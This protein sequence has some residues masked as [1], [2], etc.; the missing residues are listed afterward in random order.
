MSTTKG[1]IESNQPASP[2]LLSYP[3]DMS[4]F[5]LPLS[6]NSNTVT[7][8]QQLELASYHPGTIAQYALARWQQYLD[9]K[10]QEHI[11][12][13]LRLA[14]WLLDTENRIG[15]QAGGW[16]TSLPHPDVPTQ[17]PWLSALAQGCALSVF[18]RAYQFTQ[19]PQFLEVAHRARRT[20]QQDI[21]DG[22]VQTP[23]GANGVFFEEVGQYPAA[24]MLN[25]YI[26][27]I[28]GLYDY[29]ACTGDAFIEALIVDSIT[30]MHSILQEFDTGFWTYSNLLN[31]HLSSPEQLA[32]QVTLLEALAIRSQCNH[33][34]ALAARWKRY[35]H[36]PTSRLRHKIAKDTRK[37]GN[38]L[39]KRV[40]TALLPER[41]IEPPLR[42]CV[43]LNSLFVTGG[44]L[45]V[46]RGIAQVTVGDWQMEFLTRYVGERQDD[47]VVH[48]FGNQLMAPWQFPT[49]WV[50][51][52]D[53]FTKFVSLMRQG[54]GYHLIMPQDGVFSAAF[55]GVAGKLVGA[56][57]VCIDHAN[58]TLIKSDIYREERKKA[59]LLK[60]WPHRL[61]S[62]MLL[63]GYWPSLYL[64]AR[65][66]S[67][68]VD[69]FLVPGV[70][71]DGVED[72]C[73]ELGIHQSRLTRF[74][75]MVDINRHIVLDAEARIAERNRKQL[76]A[77][78]IVVAVICRLSTEK[79]L[80]IALETISQTLAQ[81]PTEIGKRLRVVIAGD[82]PLRQTLTEDI[83][84]RGLTQTCLLWG[85]ITAEDVIMLLAISDIFLYTSTR[86]ACI[87]MAVLEAMASG[88]AVIA[89]T[90]PMANAVLL[91]DERGIIVAP[92]DAVETASAL[93]L[94]ANDLDTCQRM[95]QAARGYIAV[96]HGATMFR[97]TLM[98][99]TS[100]SNRDEPSRM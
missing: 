84:V 16:F 58:L 95:G 100:W 54:A 22:G 98:R 90:Q 89:T 49:V 44:I 60:K 17:G 82:G 62:G 35:G 32:L 12:A 83:R 3:I 13:F 91:G 96:E 59:L 24:H 63:V 42:V 79:G 80:D 66:A 20:F 73:N 94:L 43:P 71:G 37:L 99:V 53:G 65:I 6:L 14:R 56:R 10:D 4:S 27:A 1:T 18:L 5:L 81:L 78:D 70:V 46:L 25:G 93:V 39:L 34:M 29:V 92:G 23:I 69:H 45:T 75:S 88:C 87:P 97:R 57:V 2:D 55:A 68:T 61:L 11:A 86:G 47:F 85:D 33:C 28:F 7:R 74:A 31:H 40:R 77:D 36:Q 15:E 67:A 51:A 50:Y 64:L 19:E 26:F 72:I 48:E 38:A 41:P 30:T 9:T 8:P 21:F 76:A 52:W